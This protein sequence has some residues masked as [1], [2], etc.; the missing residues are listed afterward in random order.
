MEVNSALNVQ[1]LKYAETNLVVVDLFKYSMV[2]IC[3][4]IK[5]DRGQTKP[6]SVS[7]KKKFPHQH[8]SKN[9]FVE[10]QY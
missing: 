2:S 10:T 6:Y 7:D 4:H 3:F 1:D 8:S 9:T 5:Y